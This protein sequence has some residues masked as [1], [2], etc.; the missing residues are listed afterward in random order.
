MRLIG[1]E[2]ALDA[3]ESPEEQERMFDP[4]EVV[5]FMVFDFVSVFGNPDGQVVLLVIG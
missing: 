5:L 3:F 4:L 1:F 2:Q